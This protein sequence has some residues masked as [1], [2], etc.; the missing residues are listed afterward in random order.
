MADIGDTCILGY[1]V[2]HPGFVS[3]DV[4]TEAA[5]ATGSIFMTE[6]AAGLPLE[7]LLQRGAPSTARLYDKTFGAPVRFGREH[8]AL[9]FAGPQMDRAIPGSGSASA[10]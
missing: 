4:M 1:A 5:V 2:D 10:C 8:S 3:V 7:V 9:I 6:L